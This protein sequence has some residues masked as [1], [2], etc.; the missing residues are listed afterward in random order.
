MADVVSQKNRLEK[1]LKE[2]KKVEAVKLLLDLIAMHARENQFKKPDALREKLFEVDPLALNEIVKSAEIIEGA[3]IAA[4]DPVHRRAWSNLYDPL[5]REEIIALF[6]SMKSAR[7]ETD[8]IVFRQG[9]INSNLY[10]INEGQLRIFYH[11]R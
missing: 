2:N 5:T 6:Y 8:Q 3:K 1:Y 7:Y 11:L 4:I 10:F 9:E